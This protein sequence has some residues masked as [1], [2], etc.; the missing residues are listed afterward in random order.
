MCL[1]VCQR[2]IPVSL[3]ACLCDQTVQSYKSGAMDISVMSTDM[4]TI[5]LLHLE[6]TEA[7]QT[8]VFPS[9]KLQERSRQFCFYCF[10]FILANLI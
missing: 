7:F 9:V 4:N 1:C 3:T 10:F 5:V 6:S 2:E 8:N